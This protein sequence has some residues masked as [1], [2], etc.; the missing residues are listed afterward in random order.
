MPASRGAVDDAVAQPGAVSAAVAWWARWA[1][2]SA[3]P[4]RPR[5]SRATRAAT[6]RERHQIR[7]SAGEG[8]P[9]R[10]PPAGEAPVAEGPAKAA[11]VAE[12][13]VKAGSVGEGPLAEGPVAESPVDGYGPSVGG[14]GPSVGGSAAKDGSVAGPEG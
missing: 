14:Y 11:S 3:V 2:A 12:G 6:M 8:V 9:G 1:I 13:P 4:P 5:M 10:A 7:T